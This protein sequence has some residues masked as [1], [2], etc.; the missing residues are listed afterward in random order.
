MG[1]HFLHPV[2]PITVLIFGFAFIYVSSPFARTSTCRF[3]QIQHPL[4]THDCVPHYIGKTSMGPLD[5][6]TRGTSFG[7]PHLT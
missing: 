5:L 7:V 4:Q 2:K 6:E 1:T 3:I